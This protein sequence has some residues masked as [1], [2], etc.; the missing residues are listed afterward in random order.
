MIVTQGHIETSKSLKRY[1]IV[2]DE[3]EEPGEPK[4]DKD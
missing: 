4:D 1:V 3:E 2:L